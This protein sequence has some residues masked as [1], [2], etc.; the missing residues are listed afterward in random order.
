MITTRPAAL[1]AETLRI[2]LGLLFLATATGKALDID[3]FAKVVADYRLGL[4]GPWP[5]AIAMLVTG[6]EFTVA[7]GLLGKRATSACLAATLFAHLAYAMLAMVTLARGIAL[8]NCGCFGVYFARPLRNATVVEDLVLAGI[9]AL[10]MW[11]W[12]RLEAPP[13][14]HDRPP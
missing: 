6:L 11:R 10:A 9:S 13:A 4:E 14:V 8:D 5:F 1:V 7:I 12:R 3:G 2:L